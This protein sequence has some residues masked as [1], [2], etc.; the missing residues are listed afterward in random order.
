M[1]KRRIVYLQRARGR[2]GG[3]GADAGRLD[4]SLSRVR[5]GSNLLEYR[6]AAEKFRES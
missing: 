3:G 5:A 6:D 1:E 4:T 2:R